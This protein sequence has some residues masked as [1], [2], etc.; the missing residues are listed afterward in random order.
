MNA[1]GIALLKRH[2]NAR[3]LAHPNHP[4]LLLAY[5]D[6]IGDVWSIAYGHT[7]RYG[8]P[9]G[10][11]HS[12]A[13]VSEGDQLNSGA[14]ATELLLADIAIRERRLLHKF[15]ARLNENQTAAFTCLA[16]NVGVGAV[17]NSHLLVAMRSIADTHA[18]LV[19]GASSEVIK[20]YWLQWDHGRVHG[21]E[22]VI[23]SLLARRKDEWDLF[24]AG[25]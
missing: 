10:M 13:R 22:E 11:V 23:P 4:A 6:P 25:T 19:M 24:T 2:E 1:D 17:L 8:I 21:K 9:V 7:G 5:W 3:L 20:Y 12:Q 18:S 15:P 14:E 16:Y